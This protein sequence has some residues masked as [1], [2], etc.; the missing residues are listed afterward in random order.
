MLLLLCF[1]FFFSSIYLSENLHVHVNQGVQAGIILLP[2][3]ACVDKI[4]ANDKKG[5]SSINFIIFWVL[6]CFQLNDFK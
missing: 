3:V 4:V 5:Q 1:F 6:S 2:L